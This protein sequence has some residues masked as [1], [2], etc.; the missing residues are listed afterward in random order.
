MRLLHTADWHLGRRLYGVDRTAEIAEVL[1]E[2]AEVAKRWAVDLVVV[3]GDLFDS[4]TPS[5]EAEAAA[6]RFFLELGQAGIPSVVIAGNH[7]AP[8][9]LEAVRELLK[10]SRVEL[11]GRP[12]VAQQGGVFDLSCGGETVRVAALPFVSERRIVKVAALLERDP[13]AWLSDYQAGMRKLI[14]N[15]TASFSGNCVNLLVLHGTMHGAVLANSEYSFH[16][17]EHYALPADCLPERCNYVAL[18]HI[19]KPQ[20]IAG[21]PEA[22]GRY[23]GSVVQ[24]DFGEAD[25]DKVVYLVELA[26][27]RP[28]EILEAYRIQGGK[29]LRQ[30]TVSPEQLEARQGELER[31]N[32]YLKLVLALEAPRPGLKERILR[33]LPNVLSVEL[34]LPQPAAE[35]VAP[36]AGELDLLAAYDAYVVSERG[37]PPAEPLRA[38]LRALLQRLEEEL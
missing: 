6:Y 32:G 36:A 28:S 18:G 25:D 10:L 2:I 7:D 19:H 21:Y 33:A 34:R 35:P 16:T 27:N 15:L 24:L 1:A 13:G 23:A 26:P 5:A 11:V 22:A 3:A 37:S 9:R 30:L 20:P 14:A 31:F 4:K 8:A 38:R 29:P 12:R 17:A